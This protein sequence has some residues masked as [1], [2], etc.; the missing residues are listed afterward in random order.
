MVGS[1]AVIGLMFLDPEFRAR[2]AMVL[3]G[4]SKAGILVSTLYLMFLAG[5]EHR[6]LFNFTGLPIRS[7]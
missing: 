2:P 5:N 3:D 7:C 4:L 6:R 1:D